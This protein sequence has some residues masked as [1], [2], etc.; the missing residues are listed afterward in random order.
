MPVAGQTV[1]REHDGSCPPRRGQPQDDQSAKHNGRSRHHCLERFARSITN[2][3]AAMPIERDFRRWRRDQLR[4]QRYHQRG[5][6]RE[7][8]DRRDIG[9]YQRKARQRMREAQRDHQ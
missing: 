8:D 4:R 5:P 6:G 3:R 7:F 1:G 2:L 9:G